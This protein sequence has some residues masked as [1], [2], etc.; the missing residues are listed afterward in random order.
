MAL[1]IQICKCNVNKCKFYKYVKFYENRY[2]VYGRLDWLQQ[3][4]K[5]SMSFHSCIIYVIVYNSIYSV[6]HSMSYTEITEVILLRYLKLLL[7]NGLKYFCLGA[8]TLELIPSTSRY[9]QW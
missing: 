8:V 3:T 1:A 4:I 9:F 7:F 2:L 5:T 6:K